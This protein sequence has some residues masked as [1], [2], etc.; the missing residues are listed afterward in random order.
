MATLPCLE[1][2]CFGEAGTSGVFTKWRQRSPRFHGA[3]A[4]A[5]EG[6]I[7]L[8]QQLP[9]RSELIASTRYL[10]VSLLETDGGDRWD[11]AMRF[12]AMLIPMVWGFG[13]VVD[14]LL[15]SFQIYPGES[16]FFPRTTCYVYIMSQ[17]SFLSLESLENFFVVPR[18]LCCCGC[19]IP[20]S[21]YGGG[22][23]PT[24]LWSICLGMTKPPG[25]VFVQQAFWM[26]TSILAF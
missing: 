26:F 20:R 7:A 13:M 24:T 11:W 19:L 2:K 14:G 10:S 17:W 21:D 6:A 25:M 9:E 8:W 3:L 12:E 1:K 15:I 23:N 5:L 4:E 22:L 18:Y 16:N